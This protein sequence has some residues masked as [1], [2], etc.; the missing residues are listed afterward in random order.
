MSATG[1]GAVTQFILTFR[2]GTA[3]ASREIASMAAAVCAVVS[4]VDT[5]RVKEAAAT[6]LHL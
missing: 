1:V 3:V 6:R 4:D 2:L 5:K